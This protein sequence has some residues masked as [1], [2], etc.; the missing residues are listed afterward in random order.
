MVYALLP[1]SP[2]SVRLHQQGHNGP[3]VVDD[4]ATEFL[5]AVVAL[6]RDQQRM[7][8]QSKM[9]EAMAAEVLDPCRAVLELPEPKLG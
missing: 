5:E 2:D 8:M 4:E 9:K 3:G 1:D 7:M 6:C